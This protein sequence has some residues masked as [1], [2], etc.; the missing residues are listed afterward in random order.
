M[1]TPA[2]GEAATRRIAVIAAVHPLTAGAAPFN[3]ALVAALEELGPVDILSWRRMYPPVLDRGD[4]PDVVSQ[5][6]RTH[7]ASFSLDW[8]DPRTWRRAVQRIARFRADAL[9][10]PWL[11]PVMTPPYRWF[12]RHVSWRVRRVVICHNVRPHESFPGAALLTRSTLRH[13][14]LLVTHAPHQRDELAELRVDVPVLEAFHPRFVAADL[15]A[16]PPQAAV[17]AERERLGDP[18]L[19][20]LQFGAVRQYK[21]LD[22]ALEALALTDP[23]LSVRLV[24]AGRFWDGAA[25]YRRL[26][27][28]LGVGNRV[29][30]RD[31][32]VS[33]EEAALLFSA[34]DAAILPYRSAS[35]SG[36]AQLAFAYGRPVIASAVGGLPAAVRHGRDGILCEPGDPAALARAIERMASEREQLRA[37][38][39]RDHRNCSFRS[40]AEGLHTALGERA[41]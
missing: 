28:R 4:K 12:L 24:V 9:V 6:P 36:V 8:L 7:A 20:L 37:A 10:L 35:Q 38:V 22:V 14:D 40:Y 3:D 29:V 21:G 33:D 15:A 26:A 19:L 5:P 34:A 16:I 23:S 39:R 17:R 27:D 31:G 30:I 13:A 18:G 41:A 11:H 25:G 2:T 1:T 32:Y